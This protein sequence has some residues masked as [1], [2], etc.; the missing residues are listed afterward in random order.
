MCLY[1][2]DEPTE[3]VINSILE[4]YKNVQQDKVKEEQEKKAKVL[5][6]VQGNVYLKPDLMGSTHISIA[7]EKARQAQAVK[8]KEEADARRAAAKAM[9]KEEK[10]QREKLMK[11]YGYD[12]DEVRENE[13]GETEIVYKDRAGGQAG[14]DDSA[15][16]ANRNADMIKEQDQRRR[17][18]MKDQFERE[19][20]RNKILLEK[21]R[22][23]E[24]KEKRRTQK[25]EKRRM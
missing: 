17:K 21:Q 14:P 6:D 8:E 18:E 10:A 24:E 5:E 25:K 23:K 11:Q 15:L 3:A 4:G 13:K 9:T 19:K 12:L 22:L 16:G 2:Q 7:R 1:R 20:E